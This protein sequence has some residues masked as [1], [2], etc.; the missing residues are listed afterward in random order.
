MFSRF[1]RDPAVLRAI[2]AVP[3]GQE[4]RARR[5]PYRKAMVERALAKV[6]KKLP[7][8]SARRLHAVVH[9]LASADGFLHMNEFW[10][11]SAGDGP[12]E[13]PATDD[14]YR[15]YSPHGPIDGT[16]HLTASLA[17]VAHCPQAVVQNLR[18]AGHDRRLAALGRYGFS[19][20]NLDRH[21]VGR[22]MVGIDAG[23]AVLA[24]DNYLAADRVR[25]VFHSLPCVRRAMGRLKPRVDRV[26]PLAQGARAHR[27]LEEHRNIGKV[28]LDCDPESALTGQ[29]S[30]S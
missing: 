14:A 27:Y 6:T 2:Q 9:L 30:G 28:L 29:R 3:V 18:E 15:A 16:A 5:A 20:V 11:L 22:D 24:L 21:W 12:G 10:G 25:A 7:D 4:L 8:D 17:A 13:H 26:F 19:N 23:A 1:A